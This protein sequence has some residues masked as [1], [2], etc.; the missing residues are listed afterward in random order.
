MEETLSF[1]IVNPESS[2]FCL[3]KVS[4]Y[5]IISLLGNES[6]DSGKIIKI[7]CWDEEV[8]AVLEGSSN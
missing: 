6:P 3:Y 2:P 8:R 4:I 5:F 7:A 1:I